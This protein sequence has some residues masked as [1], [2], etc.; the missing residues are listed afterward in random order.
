MERDD[1][2]LVRKNGTY[3]KIKNLGWLLKNWQHVHEFH[4]RP[5]PDRGRVRLTAVLSHPRYWRFEIT[6]NDASIM[7]RWLQRPVFMNVKI[8]YHF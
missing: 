8:N 3:R 6:W 1:T 4:V 2:F 5:T 7:E